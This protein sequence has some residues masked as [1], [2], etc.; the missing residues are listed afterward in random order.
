MAAFIEEGE[1]VLP[2]K[3]IHGPLFSFGWNDRAGTQEEQLLEDRR[4]VDYI[5]EPGAYA[6]AKK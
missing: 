1:K 3:W 6:A 5:V 2:Q 4:G